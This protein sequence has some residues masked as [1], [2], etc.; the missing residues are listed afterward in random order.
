MTVTQAY[1]IAGLAVRLHVAW[2][3]LRAADRCRYSDP[4]AFDVCLSDYDSAKQA[5]R[6]EIENLPADAF[7]AVEPDDDQ[8]STDWQCPNCKR[9][10]YKVYGFECDECGTECPEDQRS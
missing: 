7:E 1:S 4:D 5:L 8:S 2:Q 3:A 9:H 10:Q 6:D